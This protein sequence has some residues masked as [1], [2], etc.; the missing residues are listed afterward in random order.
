[1]C[2]TSS[3]REG[4]SGSTAQMDHFYVLRTKFFIFF[5]WKIDVF[6][7]IRTLYGDQAC[8]EAPISFFLLFFSGSLMASQH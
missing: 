4:I 6:S 8:D 5:V 1:M 2:S 7:N 3:V